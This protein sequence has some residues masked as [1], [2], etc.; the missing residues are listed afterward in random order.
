MLQS[1]RDHT[2]GWIA[3]IIISLLIL[4][5]ALWGIHS[6]LIENTTHSVVA[7]VNGT[8]ITKSQLAIAYERMRRQ[9][10][11]QYHSNSQLPENAEVN[12]KQKA[13]QA[14]INVQLL[15][16]AS[17]KQNFMISDNQITSYLENMPE[18]QI[19]G[20]FSP[21]RFQ[22][23]LETTL[24]NVNDFYELINTTLLTEQPRLGIIFT[25]FALPNE[26]SNTIALINQERQI[27]YIVLPL[28]T[29]TKNPIQISSDKILAYYKT[30]EEEFKTPEQASIEYIE[31]GLKELFPRVPTSVEVLKKYY[32]ENT[33]SFSQPMRWKL[34]GLMIPLS[35]QANTSQVQKASSKA[36]E[37]HQQILAGKPLTSLVEPSSVEKADLSSA[38]VNASQIPPELQKAVVSLTK[39]NQIAS[40]VRTRK[41]IYI[42]QA[43]AIEEPNVMPFEKVKAEVKEAF[44]RQQAE[45]KLAEAREKLS[46]LAYEH[47]ESLLTASQTLGLPI[48]TTHLFSKEKGANDISANPKIREASFS[49]EILNLKNNSDLIALNGETS[50]V[51]R[52]KSYIPASL[53]PLKTV[54]NEIRNKLTILELDSQA[55]N[56]ILEIKQTLEKN[57]NPAAIAT[58][59]KLQWSQPAFVSRRSN[60]IDPS[61]LEIAFALPKPTPSKPSYGIAR[62]KEGYAIV[63][64]SAL[65]ENAA[66]HSPQYKIY[67][68]QIQNTQGLMEY[69]L[70]KKS[71]QDKAKVVVEK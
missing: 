30:H 13:L 53:L 49:N 31:L 58:E 59:Y 47:P 36:N 44:V 22:Q 35:D 67:A 33:S 5:F 28:Q 61:V 66:A 60:K 23:I 43:T 7:K 65:R 52:I 17:L 18:F 62:T 24:F 32:S 12:L 20:Q 63:A 42:V 69:E 38:W 25:S 50:V 56:Q 71:M 2:Q 4:S 57:R 15:K 70:Y 68:E 37:V 26:I 45:E 48:K 27:S 14:L 21:T 54:E 46:N 8:E 10:Q 39:K 41:G 55:K 1:I 9:L 16:Q 51:I 19:D 64:L 34:E 29:L 40:P 6:Y 3:G 11:I